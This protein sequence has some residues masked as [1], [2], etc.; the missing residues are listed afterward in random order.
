MSSWWRRFSEIVGV[1]PSKK[2]WRVA[3]MQY[4]ALTR[5]EL[6]EY[7]GGWDRRYVHYFDRIQG[8]GPW[9]RHLVMG[10]PIP[11]PDD[12]SKGVVNNGVQVVHEGI[13]VVHN[14]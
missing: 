13:K 8:T 3:T 1:P 2:S 6:A 7:P 9:A 11:Q 12:D 14:G 5:E 4:L 10:G